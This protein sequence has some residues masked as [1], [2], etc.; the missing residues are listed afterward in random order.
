MER[1]FCEWY[2]ATKVTVGIALSGIGMVKESTLEKSKQVSREWLAFTP[3]GR[4]DSSN[5]G[6][7]T[8][9][10]WDDGDVDIQVPLGAVRERLYTPGLVAKI[11]RGEGLPAIKTPLR[12]TILSAAGSA[13]SYERAAKE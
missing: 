5:E 1:K 13:A 4:Y 2:F 12:S 10:W 3:D 9:A 6:Q 7:L 8:W 11:L